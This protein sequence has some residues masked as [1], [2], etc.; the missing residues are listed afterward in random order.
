MCIDRLGYV[1]IDTR[2]LALKKA[3]FLRGRV[4]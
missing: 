2:R 3:V 1:M 4:H